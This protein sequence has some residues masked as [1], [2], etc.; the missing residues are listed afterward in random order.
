MLIRSHR[1]WEASCKILTMAVQGPSGATADGGV[2]VGGRATFTNLRGNNS[3]PSPGMIYLI[4]IMLIYLQ[5][6]SFPSRT[7]FAP[8]TRARL[9]IYPLM[10]SL[11]YFLPSNGVWIITD[12]FSI[13]QLPLSQIVFAHFFLQS[14]HICL[15]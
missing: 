1:K 10:Y 14:K 6:S 5:L 13:R 8:R 2:G 4:K 9:F 11:L 7:Q 15:S 12:L 3:A